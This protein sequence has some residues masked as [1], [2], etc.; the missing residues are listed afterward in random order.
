MPITLKKKDGQTVVFD[1]DEGIRVPVDYKKLAQLKTI[2]KENGYEF[3]SP[4]EDRKDIGD[5]IGDNVNI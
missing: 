5:S 1:K 4:L 3:I 2:F